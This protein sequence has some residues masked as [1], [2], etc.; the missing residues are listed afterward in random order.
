M[1]RKTIWNFQDW[2][3]FEKRHADHVEAFWPG[4][5]EPTKGR[6][7][8]KEEAIEFFKIFPDNHVGNDPYKVLFGQGKWTCSVA[9]FT[10][11]CK[12]PVTGADG[13][14][15]PPTG[16]S[17]K[18]EFCTV[19]HWINGEIVEEKLFYDKIELM[20]HRPYVKIDHGISVFFLFETI[21][22]FKGGFNVVVQFLCNPTVEL[23]LHCFKN[24]LRMLV[25]RF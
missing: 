12:G 16:K 1:R 3:T 20:K 11:T 6:S 18:V 4:Q 24:S 25:D 7:S 5:P 21:R 14:I 13:T 19:A 22:S 10:G 2:N 8:H 23:V 15:I 17:F 9:E